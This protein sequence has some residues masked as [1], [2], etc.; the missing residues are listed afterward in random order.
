MKYYRL[1]HSVQFSGKGLHSGVDVTMTVRPSEGRGVVF[2]RIDL[3]GSPRIPAIIDN[4]TDTTRGTT[5]TGESGSEVRTV[6]HLLSALAGLRIL[7]CLVDIDGIE[8]PTLDGSSLPFVRQL[9]SALVEIDEDLSGHYVIEKPFTFTCETSGSIYHGSPSATLDIAVELSFP[10]LGKI[11]SISSRFDDL[12]NVYESDIAPARTFCYSSE[13][14]DLRRAGLIK[15]GTITNAVVIY[16]GEDDVSAVLP[17]IYDTPPA[18][19]VDK[20]DP[21]HAIAGGSLRFTDEPARHKALD[22]LGDLSLLGYPI[23]GKLVAIKPG[24]TGNISLGRFVQQQSSTGTISL[25]TPSNR[26]FESMDINEIRSIIPHRYPFLL[27][28]KIVEIDREAGHIVGVK[29]V[30]ANEPFFQGHFPDFPIMPGVLLVEAMAQTGGIL[31]KE[32]LG[33]DDSKLAVFMGI[34]EAKFRKPVVPGDTVRLE[35]SLTGKKFNTYSMTGKAMVDNALVAQA[36]ISVAV[37]D[38]KM[39]A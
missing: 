30:T 19:E 20:I 29:N 5:L 21:G 11:P 37:I 12:L 17:Q 36:E 38:K 27:V 22:M 9:S 32:A 31:L 24:H 16:D 6:E 18:V 4:V 28:D 33:D 25:S 13:L 23:Q 10:T 14:T 35:L 1:E 39:G 26:K 7:N 8:V 34:R 15:G 3:D 2:R